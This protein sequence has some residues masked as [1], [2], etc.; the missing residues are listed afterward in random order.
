MQ[1]FETRRDQARFL[2]RVIDRALLQPTPAHR[3]A[4]LAA[5]R[6][7]DTRRVAERVRQRATRLCRREPALAQAL[8]ARRD[9]FIMALY[10]DL[11]PLGWAN[12]WCDGSSSTQ[13]SGLH[14]GVGVVVLDASGTCIGE[15]GRH[16]GGKTAFEAELTALML[17]LEIALAHDIERLRVHTDSKA[18]AQLWQEHREDPRLA[19]VRALGSRFRGLH[20]YAIPRLH[21]QVAN[22][23][24]RQ[25]RSHNGV[26]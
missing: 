5:A 19:P 24:A 7:R 17:V 3:D 22:A 20:I 9:D 18:L 4:L 11:A 10:A 16:V 1:S 2:N 26:S 21:N 6:Q 8:L 13:A 15:T 25:A 12:A 23:L 14:A